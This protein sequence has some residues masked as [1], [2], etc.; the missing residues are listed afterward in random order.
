LNQL[1]M[2]AEGKPLDDAAA[3]F[4]N[5]GL[6]GGGRLIG[7]AAGAFQQPLSKMP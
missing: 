1:L 5:L 4:G 6:P 7:A 2:R 3:C